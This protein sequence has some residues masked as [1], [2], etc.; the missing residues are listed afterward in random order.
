MA[1]HDSAK[2][3]IRKTARQT[4]VNRNRISRIRTF[5]KRV[6]AAI[7]DKLPKDSVLESFSN[8]QK[9]IMQGVSKNVIHKNAAAR[10]VSR[11]HKRVKS[12][13]GESI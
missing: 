13:I 9:E 4:V 2:K 8:M 10:K 5:I 7:S 11:I 3:S 12:A 1:S 6:E